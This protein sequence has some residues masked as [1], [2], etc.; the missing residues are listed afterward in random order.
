MPHESRDLFDGGILEQVLSYVGPGHWLFIAE[1]CKLWQQTYRMIAI[2]QL[3]ALTRHILGVGSKLFACH[4]KMTLGQAVFASQSRLKWAHDAGLTIVSRRDSDMHKMEYL[5]GLCADLYT[6]ALAV[7]LES[8]LQSS[9]SVLLG[10]AASGCTS[11]VSW[12]CDQRQQPLPRQVMWF[13]ASSGNLDML[14]LVNQPNHMLKGEGKML[15][16]IAA[17]RGYLGMCIYLRSEGCAWDTT[18]CAHAV[19]GCHLRTLRWLHE[20]GC[21]WDYRSLCLDAARAGS[22]QILTYL[23]LHHPSESAQ[24]Q[25]TAALL[26]EMLHCAGRWDQLAAAQWLREVGAQWPAQL[27]ATRRK[28]SG[29]VLAWARAEGCTAPI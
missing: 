4:P 2:A 19:A 16:R 8:G 26:T 9:D 7:E 17:E 13:A 1:V 21:P 27:H 5:A 3:P 28:W 20:G 23:Q 12:L 24:W 22:V 11:K 25:W 18:V 14:Q 29:A 15:I 10:A 6:L